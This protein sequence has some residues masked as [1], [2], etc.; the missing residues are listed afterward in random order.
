MTETQEII[1]LVAKALEVPVSKVN[2]NSS[3]ETIP[4]WDSF[5]NILLMEALFRK[6]PKIVDKPDMVD[7]TSVQKIVELVRNF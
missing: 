1:E 6:Y 7:T 4:E 3:M 2:E 5:G